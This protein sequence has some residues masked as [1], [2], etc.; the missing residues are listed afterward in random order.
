MQC[1]VEFQEYINLPYILISRISLQGPHKIMTYNEKYKLGMIMKSL[2]GVTFD[3]PFK[4]LELAAP[5]ATC[6]VPE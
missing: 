5:H 6:S 1:D 4:Q 2:N 3:V